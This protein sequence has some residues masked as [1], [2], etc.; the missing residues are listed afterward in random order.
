MTT[1]LEMVRS[2][3]A[4]DIDD[5]HVL[6][7][8]IKAQKML[9]ETGADLKLVKPENIHVT[10]KFLG[11]IPTTMVDEI[12]GEMEKITFTQFKIELKGLGAFP[13]LRR[14]R[15]IWA[16][17]R[18]GARELRDIYNQLELNLKA[19]GFKADPKG[20]SPHL[21]IVRVRTGRNRN[22]LVRCIEQLADQDFGTVEVKC[23]RLKRSVL[24][25]KGPIYSVLREVCR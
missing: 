20:F 18:E 14:I 6:R 10:M 2:F 25:P 1:T 16:G 21:T 8:I 12:H 17:I 7:N 13:N 23:L 11:S 19:L 15:V 4:F 9:L 5:E 22:N 3:I 24:T